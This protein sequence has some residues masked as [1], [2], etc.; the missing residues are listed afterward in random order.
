MNTT[1]V[2]GWVSEPNG[3]GTLDIVWSCLSTI[4]FCSW[5][6]LCLN[7]PVAGESEFRQFRRKIKWMIG[8]IVFPE[9]VLYAAF[10]QDIA[11]RRSVERFQKL[12]RTT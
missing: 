5:S 3:R 6:V 2:Y 9:M 10:M 4:F 1:V 7:I 12:N 11:A 8:T